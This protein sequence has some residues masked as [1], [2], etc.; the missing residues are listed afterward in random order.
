MVS[1]EICIETG[2]E[3]AQ[4][5][6][7]LRCFPHAVAYLDRTC[8]VDGCSKPRHG[9]HARCLGHLREQARPGR[10]RRV[11]SE[12]QRIPRSERQC[13]IDGCSRPVHAKDL[14]HSHYKTH[15]VR[16]PCTIEGCE[17]GMHAQ[18]LCYRHYAQAYDRKELP[19]TQ[20]QGVLTVEERF[21]SKVRITSTCHIWEG[22]VTTNGR[23]TFAFP[24]SRG[25][26]SH[27]AG[28]E[29]EFGPI[30]TDEDDKPLHLDH[31]CRIPL[32]VR[33]DHLEPVPALE[34][35][36]RGA[37]ADGRRS[38]DQRDGW[39]LFVAIP[40]WQRGASN[41]PSSVVTTHPVQVAS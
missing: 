38:F 25:T 31:G 36:R 34:N 6:G 13:R 23:G 35:S 24:G 32:C 10:K 5:P 11:A 14:C 21:R 12:P 19:R 33:P 8:N 18:G 28:Y 3:T 20:L 4:V 15:A 7:N 1:T 26:Q 27:R 30:P 2:C 29:F 16:K 41:F 17:R 40:E 9:K 39:L 22:T 37:V